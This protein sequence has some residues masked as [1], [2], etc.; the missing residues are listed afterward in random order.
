MREPK[1]RLTSGGGKGVRTE[2]AGQICRLYKEWHPRR[3]AGLPWPGTWASRVTALWLFV[4]VRDG[5]PELK[6]GCGR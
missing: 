6:P 4:A 3:G 2:T 5:L 1:A